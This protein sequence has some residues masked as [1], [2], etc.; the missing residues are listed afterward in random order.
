MRTLAAGAALLVVCGILWPASDAYLAQ[1]EEWRRHREAALKADGGWLTVT[2]LFWLHDGT[3]S[4]SSTSPSASILLPAG[5]GVRDGEFDLHNGRVLLRLDG[6][7]RVLRPDT[8]GQPDGVTMGSLSMF[9]IVRGDRYG[10]RLKDT[11]SSLRKQFTGLHYFPVSEDYRV[12]TR[13]VPD[14]KKIPIL[15]VLGQVEPTPSPGY[16]EFEIHGQKLRLTPVEE[17]P[18]ELSFIF[19][20]LTAGKETYGSGRF[21]DAELGKDGE[22]VLD[23]NKAYNPPCAFTPYATCPLPPKENRLAARIEAGELKYG[24]H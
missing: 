24:S 15:N 12:T 18:N 17:S 10:I 1:I 9:V 6:Q 14:A 16:V 22:V 7:N 21:L 5:P 20:D 23:F 4:F 8:A 11:N 13:L 19:R 3:N 2:G